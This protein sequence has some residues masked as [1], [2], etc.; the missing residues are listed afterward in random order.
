MTMMITITVLLGGSKSRYVRLS[1]TDNL[2]AAFSTTYKATC[3][4]TMTLETSKL[5]ISI[6]SFNG[7]SRALIIKLY[8]RI[9][10]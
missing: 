1:C 9:E 10:I 8:L 4:M 7:L 2:L 5:T 3:H 6:G